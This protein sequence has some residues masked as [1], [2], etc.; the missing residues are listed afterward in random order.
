MTA[1]RCSYRWLT[2]RN[3]VH[4]K[5]HRA[6]QRKE[7]HCALANTK[8]VYS[9]REHVDERQAVLRRSVQI[10]RQIFNR[11]GMIHSRMFEVSLLAQGLEE[12]IDGKCD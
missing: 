12:V 5:R 9:R 8:T 10:Q 1:E 2:F 4:A 11:P 3:R 6:S 7:R